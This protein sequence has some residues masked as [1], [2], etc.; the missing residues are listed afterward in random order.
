MSEQR[1]VGL[2]SGK[3]MAIDAALAD[4]RCGMKCPMSPAARLEYIEDLYA[5]RD[6]DGVRQPGAGII[7]LDDYRKLLATPYAPSEP[8]RDSP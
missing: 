4:D 5:P 1:P 7:S 2:D 8:H 6:E 3:A